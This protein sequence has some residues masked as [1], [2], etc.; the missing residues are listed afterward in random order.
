MWCVGFQRIFLFC[1]KAEVHPLIFMSKRFLFPTSVLLRG[2]TE[3][4]N[5]GISVVVVSG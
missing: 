2:Y 1:V 3:D 5:P 4:A